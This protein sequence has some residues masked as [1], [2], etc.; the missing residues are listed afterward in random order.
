MHSSNK[1]IEYQRRKYRDNDVIISQYLQ[2]FVTTI[3]PSFLQNET[4]TRLDEIE[5]RKLNLTR[6]YIIA[7]LSDSRQLNTFS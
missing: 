6:S 2:Y 1:N 7:T 4:K 5:A 3:R